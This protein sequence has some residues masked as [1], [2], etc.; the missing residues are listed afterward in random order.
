MWVKQYNAEK[1]KYKSQ[2][3]RHM[4]EKIFKMLSLIMKVWKKELHVNTKVP[5]I[6]LSSQ[7]PF[8]WSNL[9]SCV[10]EGKRKKE[11]KKGEN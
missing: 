2:R 9:N 7:L 6:Y 8:P 11:G 1:C 5:K 4:P 10:E 3:K